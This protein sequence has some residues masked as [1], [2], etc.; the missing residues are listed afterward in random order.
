[1]TEQ[2]FDV[3]KYSLDR[4]ISNIKSGVQMTDQMLL[5]A[6]TPEQ[7]EKA[8]TYLEMIIKKT[9]YDLSQ[10]LVEEKRNVK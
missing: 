6:T 10:I 7:L 9:E 4:C 1:M 3:A 8:K 2:N 5:M